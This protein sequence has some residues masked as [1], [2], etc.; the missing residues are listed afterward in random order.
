VLVY[1]IN[2]VGLAET[3]V[4][5]ARDR[6]RAALQNARF[7]VSAAQGDGESRPGRSAEGIRPLRPAIA[8]GILAAS[9]QIAALT[10]ARA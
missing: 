9:G 6:V 5:E 4:R 2:I 8:I 10:A 7:E 1:G 3:E